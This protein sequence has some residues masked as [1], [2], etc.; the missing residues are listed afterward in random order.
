MKFD[1]YETTGFYDEIFEASDK[2]RPCS[3]LLIERL[4]SFSHEEIKKRQRSADAA[5]FNMGVT[6]TVYEDQAGIEKIFPFDIIPRII[7]SSEWKILE[8]GLRQRIYALNQFIHDVYN[9]KKI[10]K[11][12]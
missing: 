9:D 11:D 4:K 7:E 1:N 12:R 10:I 6:F 8:K 2:P 3:K 5:L